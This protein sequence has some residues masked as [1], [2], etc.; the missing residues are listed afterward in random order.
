MQAAIPLLFLTRYIY[1][2]IFVA[3]NSCL[4]NAIFPQSK[5]LH[6]VSIG[7]HVSYLAAGLLPKKN[8]F[9]IVLTL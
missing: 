9:L 1:H 3:P 7:S 5:I 4:W 8:T 2:K 6:E